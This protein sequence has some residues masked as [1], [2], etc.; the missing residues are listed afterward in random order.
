M[1][2][3]PYNSSARAILTH[4]NVVLHSFTPLNWQKSGFEFYP[5]G[6]LLDESNDG[7]S[8]VPK[9]MDEISK[10]AR[11][12]ITVCSS[13]VLICFN[14]ATFK[15]RQSQRFGFPT[16]TSDQPEYQPTNIRHR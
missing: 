1:V 11:K 13:Q 3:I 10:M 4:F 8:P 16:V 6:R 7:F 5:L 12:E 15:S 2:T 9:A 14:L